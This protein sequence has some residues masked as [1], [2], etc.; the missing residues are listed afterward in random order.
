MSVERDNK[1]HIIEFICDACGEYEIDDGVYGQDDFAFAWRGHRDDGWVST[2]VKGRWQHRCPACVE[3][4]RH[5]VE[6]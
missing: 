4:N 1:T 6:G 5:V 3:E 2:K